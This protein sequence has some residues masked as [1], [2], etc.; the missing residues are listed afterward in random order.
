[1]PTSGKR[2]HE[3]IQ[4]NLVDGDV[5]SV[6]AALKAGADPNFEFEGDLPLIF[7][8]VVGHTLAVKAL[9]EAGADVNKSS[10]HANNGITALHAASALGR[11][12]SAILLLSVPE[13]ELDKITNSGE[14]PLDI[15]RRTFKRYSSNEII[16]PHEF[17]PPI[18]S[19]KVIHHLEQAEKGIFPNPNDFGLKLPNK[20][21]QP[22]FKRT[23]RNFAD[24]QN[25][26]ANW[27]R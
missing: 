14:T 5:T 10:N 20:D 21:I 4:R 27:V 8:V 26:T 22:S 7:H 2:R 9:I 23:F 13:I 3:S 16:S 18:D 25:K 11:H 19:G 6:V 24:R 17:V 12:E 1:M 15:A